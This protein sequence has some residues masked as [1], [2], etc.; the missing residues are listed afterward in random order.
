MA[1]ALGISRLN[2]EEAVEISRRLIEAGGDV[3]FRDKDGNTAMH[4]AARGGHGGLVRLLLSRN[5]PI[6][7]ILFVYDVCL[8]LM[9]VPLFLTLFFRCFRCSK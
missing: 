2:C 9:N 7:E 5:C 6:G 4:W 8:Y 1:A 3:L